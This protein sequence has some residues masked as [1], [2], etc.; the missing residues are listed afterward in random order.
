MDQ[1][2]IRVIFSK[3]RELKFVLLGTILGFLSYFIGGI[4]VF[5]VFLLIVALIL[6]FFRIEIA[7]LSLPFFIIID[8]LIKKYKN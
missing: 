1:R 2:N 5:L 8:F 6:S 7:L 3:D 4:N